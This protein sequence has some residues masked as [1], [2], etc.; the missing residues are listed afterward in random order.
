MEPSVG[1][2]PTRGSFAD[3]RVSTSPTGQNFGAADGGRTHI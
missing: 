1:I 3:Y 2:E